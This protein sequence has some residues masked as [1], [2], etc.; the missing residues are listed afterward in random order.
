MRRKIRDDF[1]NCEVRDGEIVRCP[2]MLMDSGGR[3]RRVLIGDALADHLRF[4]R[5][6]PGYV[7]DALAHSTKIPQR[8]ADAMADR[9]R[10][11]RLRDQRGDNAWKTPLNAMPPPPPEPAAQWDPDK[12]GDDDENENG[13]GGNGGDD[14]DDENALARAQQARDDAYEA[15]RIRG[16]NAWRSPPNPYTSGLSNYGGTLDPG[17]ADEVEA[18]RRKTVLR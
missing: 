12:N 13:N 14:H 2:V 9:E 18:I 8:L 3:R 17:R 11:Y 10:A 7:A 16:D 5:H 15:R 6:R 1:D 4:A